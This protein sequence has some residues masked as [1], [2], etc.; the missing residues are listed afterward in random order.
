MAGTTRRTGM[1]RR[2]FLGLMGG[3]GAAV[4]AGGALSA[5]GGLQEGGGAGSDV[6]RIGYVSPETG[7]LAPFGEADQFVVSAIGEFFAR[8]P[9]QVGGT[10]YPVEILKRDSQSDSNRAADVAADLIQNG[11]IHLMLVSSTPDTSNPVSDQCE[12]NGMPCISTVTP[13]QPWFFGRGG[14]EGSRFTWTYNFFWGLE[15]VAAVFSDM[16]GRVPSNNVAGALWPNDPDGL[17]WVLRRTAPLR[18]A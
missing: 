4:V 10:A 14:T 3:A 1:D 8:N 16:W 15:D 2:R 9:I 11:G 5:C 13:W 12:A 18:A 6:I 17:A 7:P